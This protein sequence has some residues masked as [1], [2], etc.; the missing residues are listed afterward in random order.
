MFK[1]FKRKKSEPVIDNREKYVVAILKDNGKY[2][3]QSSSSG[4]WYWT[5]TFNTWIL[6]V[7]DD[8][9]RL[10]EFNSSVDEYYHNQAKDT[11]LYWKFIKPWEDGHDDFSDQI[12]TID[13]IK[14][15]AKPFRNYDER[16]PEYPKQ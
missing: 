2:R 13:Q 1:F 16:I 9:Q 15:G 10:I 12:P 7:Y 3:W 6:N 4:K 14:N 5:K 8:G 11:T